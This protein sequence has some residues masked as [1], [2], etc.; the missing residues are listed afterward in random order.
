MTLFEHAANNHGVSLTVWA[1]SIALSLLPCPLTLG[2]QV[3]DRAPLG[4]NKIN[5]CEHLLC[6]EHCA[7]CWVSYWSIKICS[8]GLALWSCGV[9]LLPAL[10]ASLIRTLFSFL[11][12]FHCQSSSLLLCL[13]KQWRMA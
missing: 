2:K 3:V 12:L 4:K 13:G 1:S 10:P 8:R 11:G 7:G 6:M 9:K 5:L